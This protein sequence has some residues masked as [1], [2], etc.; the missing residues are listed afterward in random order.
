[1]NSRIGI[2]GHFAN[3]KE[4][5]DGQTVSTRLWR[6]ELNKRF[7]QKVFEVDT[8][9]NRKRIL[10]ILLQWLCCMISC[11]HII[12]ILSENGLRVFLPLLY[13]SNKFF[14]R[15]IYH[16]AIGGNTANGVIEN[17]KYVRYYNALEVNWVQSNTM[18][19]QLTQLGINN[20]EKLENFRNIKPINLN[21]K[22]LMWE[23]EY[24]F[25]TFSRVTKTKGITE[26]IVAISNVNKQICNA[27]KA[28]LH[29]YGPV[30]PEYEVEFYDL[31]EKNKSCVEYKGVIKAHDAVKVLP[32]YYFHL[33]PTV[34]PGEGFPGTIIDCFNSGLPTI[35]SNWAFN[36]EFIHNEINGL[37]YDWDKPEQLTD[38]IIKSIE[39]EEKYLDYVEENLKEAAKYSC[40][41]VMGKILDRMGI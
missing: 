37:I 5:Y 4:F 20:A 36:S 11:D 35:A 39:L 32:N 18:V 6:D 34:W 3:G 2:I 28:V 26:A 41:N 12:I 22:K 31:L 33:F 7:S 30:D 24:L 14:H 19:T 15:K 16:R 13:Y 23:N 29:I 10:P 8:Y 25:C 17:P 21:E 1:M 9:N 38:L 27:K 40:E